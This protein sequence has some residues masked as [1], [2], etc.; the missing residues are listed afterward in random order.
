M[1]KDVADSF[2]NF[3]LHSNINELYAPFCCLIDLNDKILDNFIN[4][5]QLISIKDDTL[6][7][8]WLNSDDRIISRYIVD[9]DKKEELLKAKRYHQIAHKQC[10]INISNELTEHMPVQDISNLIS[11]FCG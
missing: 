7:Y 6:D 8:H 5:K 3:L 2:M 10:R 11:S 1:G 9:A 4:C